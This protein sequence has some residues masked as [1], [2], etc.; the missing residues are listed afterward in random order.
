M[1]TP[2]SNRPWAD[3]LFSRPLPRRWHV[4]NA[5]IGVG[6]TCGQSALPFFLGQGPLRGPPWPLP[7]DGASA[8]A[9][10]VRNHRS[11]VKRECQA[12]EGN[13]TK[14]WRTVS[15]MTFGYAL[16]LDRRRVPSVSSS[17]GSKPVSRQRCGPPHG[18][19]TLPTSV[20][21]THH[22]AGQNLRAPTSRGEL[23]RWAT[24]TPPRP[25]VGGWQPQGP[26]P[27]ARHAGFHGWPP[28][29]ESRSGHGGHRGAGP[30]PPLSGRLPTRRQPLLWGT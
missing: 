20:H 24:A 9:N 19:G 1:A 7:A 16:T 8:H 12:P 18:H 4:R 6:S 23:Q 14:P 21:P 13:M 10:P 25:T 5:C 30:R 22:C 2:R 3:S 17:Q 29:G 11:S 27:G 15:S 26:E 28:V